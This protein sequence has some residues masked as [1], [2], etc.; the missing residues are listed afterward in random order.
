MDS[1]VVEHRAGD[2]VSIERLWVEFGDEVCVF[3]LFQRVEF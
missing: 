3:Y 1:L 2:P